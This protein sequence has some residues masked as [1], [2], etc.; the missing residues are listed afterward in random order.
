MAAHAADLICGD[1]IG[2]HMGVLAQLL[3]GVAACMGTLT[4]DGGAHQFHVLAQLVSE[5]LGP[6]ALCLQQAGLAPLGC[7]R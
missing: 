6:V 5:H 7:I 2:L 1:R 4:A 3:V